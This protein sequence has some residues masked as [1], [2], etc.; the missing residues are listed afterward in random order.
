MA[1]AGRGPAPEAC[2]PRGQAD[3]LMRI[4]GGGRGTEAEA[5]AGG[6][7]PLQ[8][9]QQSGHVSLGS[10]EAVQHGSHLVTLGTMASNPP[11]NQG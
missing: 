6:V 11:S 9:G 5:G 7:K 4:W 8:G 3:H 2:H 1:G 10:A